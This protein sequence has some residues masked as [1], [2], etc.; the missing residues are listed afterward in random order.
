MGNFARWPGGGRAIKFP[1]TG[2]QRRK[3][4][5]SNIPDG[6]ASGMGQATYR[7]FRFIT[8]GTCIPGVARS[9]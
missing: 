3:S 6:M 8:L 9:L 7:F 4:T 2:V 1:A 5:H